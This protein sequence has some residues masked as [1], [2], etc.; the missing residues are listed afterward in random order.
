[1]L[2]HTIAEWECDD[3]NKQYICFLSE[4]NKWSNVSDIFKWWI[5]E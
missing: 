1:M 2:F 3:S 4:V 5:P